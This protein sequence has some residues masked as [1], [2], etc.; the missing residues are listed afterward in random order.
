VKR[1]KTIDR[2]GRAKATSGREA[3]GYFGPGLARRGFY[4]ANAL[5]PCGPAFARLGFMGARMVESA[6]AGGE[7]S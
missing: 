6:A 7:S 1:W 3:A 2:K 5:A 4:G